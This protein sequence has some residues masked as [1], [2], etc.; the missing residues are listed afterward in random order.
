MAAGPYKAG[1]PAGDESAAAIRG[2][3][4]RPDVGRILMRF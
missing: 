2:P 1:T 3:I 4:C